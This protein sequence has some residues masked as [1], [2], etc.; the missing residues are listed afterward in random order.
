MTALP[1]TFSLE[2]AFKEQFATFLSAG[3]SPFIAAIRLWPNDAG[4]ASLVANTWPTDPYVEAY[5]EKL[6][7][8]AEAKLK[9]ADKTAQIKRIEARLD[10]LTEDNYLK[11]ERLLAEMSGHI[12]KA[13]PPSVNI[14]NR[15]Q[16]IER[17][18]V[19]KDHGDDAAWEAKMS[20]QQSKLIEGNV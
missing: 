8:D 3:F 1:V 19:I 13:A 17:V 10:T 16:T 5:R 7:G 6:K 2:P 15:Q 4:L 18:L 20:A 11:A 14:D 9:P 12:E